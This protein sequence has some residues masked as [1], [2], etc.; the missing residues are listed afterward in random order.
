MPDK[1][2]M[3]FAPWILL[4]SLWT[5]MIIVLLLVGLREYKA[6]ISQHAEI[7][8][9]TSYNKDITYR[10]WSS[11]HG[12]TY[13]PVTKETQPNP[14]LSD[15]EERDIRTPSG[16][17]LT[18]LNPAY[19]TRQVY[20]LA[21]ENFGVQGHITSLMPL[22][23]ENRADSWESRNL[24]LFDSGQKEK[25]IEIVDIDGEPFLR[26]IYPM[27]TEENCLRCHLSQGYK[28][29]DIRGGLSFTVPISPYLATYH[30]VRTS[31]ITTLLLLWVLGLGLLFWAMNVI[32]KQFFKLEESRAKAANS[33]ARY[34]DLFNGAEYGIAIVDQAQ[35]TIIESN[36]KLSELIGRSRAELIG[37]EQA[38]LPN[39]ADLKTTISGKEIELTGPS[40]DLLSVAVKKRIIMVDGKLTE[41]ILFYD[42]TDEKKSEK[43]I[44]ATAQRI[45]DIF[46]AA[47]NVSFI[48][49][50]TTEDSAILEFSPGAERIFGY[51]KEEAIGQPVSILHA[52]GANIADLQTHMR[53]NEITFSG[54]V[55]LIRKSGEIFP[56]WFTLYPLFDEQG[57]LYGRL[58]VSID[59]SELKELE[60][61][62]VQTQKMEAIGTLAGGIAH[63]FNNIL[64]IIFGYTQLATRQV[65][66]DSKAFK[67][68]QTIEQAASR[69]KELVSQILT[70]SR[71]SSQKKQVISLQPIIKESVKLLRSTLPK[72]IEIVEKIAADD[73]KVMADPT[74][75]HQVL[76]NLCTNAYHAMRQKGGTLT[77]TYSDIMIDAHLAAEHAELSVGEYVLLQIRDTGT[78]INEDI[79][80]R[81]FDPFFT[82]KITENG[83]G[84]GLS[85]VHGIIQ[86]HQGIILVET[87]ADKGSCFSIYLPKA[88]EATEAPH[89]SNLSGTSGEERI[90]MVDDEPMLAALGRD[91]LSALGY[92]IKVAI[93]SR[94]ALEI[95]AADP[96]G[97]DLVV[98][99]QTMPYMTGT[100]L[101]KEL[102]RI[103][104]DLPVII[105]TGFSELIN[106]DNFKQYGAKRLL[107][108][109]LEKNQLAIAIRE[110]FNAN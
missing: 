8:A 101:T 91:L 56:A 63:D 67:H 102:L 32:R 85:V 70:F 22:R 38:I 31:L 50:E 18:L 62:L 43:Q 95:F 1:R 2:L 42:R 57:N 74:Q 6:R 55:N 7:L 17:Q 51:K 93:D 53:S 13:V 46:Q 65:E 58:G 39:I 89:K 71:E 36:Q 40:G 97:F 81:I 61:R 78:G 86:D 103:R 54:R 77:V 11:Q 24:K 99:D 10:R 68:L 106:K 3:T 21:Q 107:S 73:C 14:F 87:E 98:T 12:G 29:G 82:T 35:G 100:D 34:H 30:R 72:T 37:A 76:M 15:I 59:I 84:M 44:M 88:L 4:T 75:M 19:M 27:V 83:T 109:P 52:P 20:E 28:V 96:Q 26:A 23:S 49:A 80:L 66:V 64:S 79:L 25:V 48:I 104:P 105:C 9:D 60:D 47:Q 16:R 5:G 33:E 92:K 94:K 41:E 110:I 69:A 90:L 108:K 45:R